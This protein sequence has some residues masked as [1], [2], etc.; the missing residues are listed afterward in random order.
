[1]SNPSGVPPGMHRP[2]KRDVSLQGRSIPAEQRWQSGR[3]VQPCAGWG[4]GAAVGCPGKAGHA[5]E[6]VGTGRR[7][8][9]WGGDTLGWSRSCREGEGKGGEA[10]RE[11]SR[12]GRQGSIKASDTYLSRHRAR[13][14]E[15]GSG[16]SSSSS[17]SQEERQPLANTHARWQERVRRCPCQP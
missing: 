14:R 6:Q 1:M 3:K 9:G 5:E 15:S 13:G 4:E 12:G 10:G 8:A 7:G 17:S 11:D 2:A 16:I